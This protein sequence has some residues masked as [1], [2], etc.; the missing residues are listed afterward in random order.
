LPSSSVTPGDGFVRVGRV[1]KPH[2][3][4]GSFVVEDASSDPA[5]FAVGAAL[6]VD[7]EQVRV[8]SCKQAGGR[9]VIRLDRGVERGVELCIPV[10]ELPPAAEGSYY[11]F[12]LVGLAVLEEGGRD[13]GRV[14]AVEPGVANDVL[15][16][17]SGLALP[18]HE[19]CIR[20]VDLAAGTIVVARGFAEPDYPQ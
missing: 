11:A 12:Q 3:L 13:L 20:D 2:G 14:Q 5:R 1:G 19:D 15:E 18:M 8:V 6:V 10:S 16:L 7:G 9:P 17:E 4:D